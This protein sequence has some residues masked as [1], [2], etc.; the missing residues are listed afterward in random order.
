MFF[1]SCGTFVIAFFG[2]SASP[3]C[4]GGGSLGHNATTHF[5]TNTPIPPSINHPKVPVAVAVATVSGKLNP[6]AF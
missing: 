5:P 6:L 3:E 2:T 4:L 1:T